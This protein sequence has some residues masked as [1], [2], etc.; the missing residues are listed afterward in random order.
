MKTVSITETFVDRLPRPRKD[1]K[2]K[3]YFDKKSTGF[4]VK[5]YYTGSKVYGVRISMNGNKARWLNIGAHGDPWDADAAREE[6][7]QIKLNIGN[8][9][10]PYAHR[11]PKHVSL[12]RLE[13]L[14]KAFFKHFQELVDQ[15]RRSPATL[16]EYKRQWA[17]NVPDDMKKKSVQTLRRSDFTSLHKAITRRNPRKPL[18]VEAN[19]T[20]A[21]L[22]SMM[23]WVLTLDEDLRMGLKENLADGVSRN[24][25]FERGLWMEEL[26]Q[27]RLLAFLVDPMNRILVWWPA[28]KMARVAANPSIPKRAPVKRP[29]HVLD[30][31]VLDALLLCFLT[32]LRHCEALA[33]RWDHIQKATGTFQ[34][35][36][37]KRG[38]KPG[39]QA[40]FKAIFI[41]QE[42]QELLDRIPKTS[43]WLFP[44]QGRSAKSESGHLENIQDAWERI[45]K[46]LGLGKIR[47]HDFRHT[48]ASELGDQE[49]LNARELKDSMGWKTMQ[50]A[51]R[52]MHAR[53][54]QQQVKLQEISTS[55][56]KRLKAAMV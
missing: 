51:M 47:L 9:L 10:D 37:V 27:A 19:R 6:A 26:E 33:M 30:G 52:Y 46:H 28:E 15:E 36:I 35:P 23:G 44:S 24:Q 3:F 32:G 11:A 12:N 39:A 4:G 14:A 54:R 43:E 5:V 31:A 55:R 20:V 49:N 45:R 38:A 29:P 8:G 21:L 56:M 17:K 41:T 53:E 22:C 7:R 2:A 42:I 34:V 18:T 1:E 48:M 16:K 13:D 40:E 50:T 25:E